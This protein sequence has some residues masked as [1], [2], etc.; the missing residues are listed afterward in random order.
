MFQ[1][2]FPELLPVAGRGL[3]F[4]F[5]AVILAVISPQTL[6]FLQFRFLKSLSCSLYWEINSK[7]SSAQKLFLPSTASTLSPEHDAIFVSSGNNDVII[8]AI[9]AILLRGADIAGMEIQFFRNGNSS[10]KTL[11]RSIPIILIPD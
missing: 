10:Q 1:S 11:T 3:K 2:A 5:S 8:L 6:F 7:V 9:P 4:G